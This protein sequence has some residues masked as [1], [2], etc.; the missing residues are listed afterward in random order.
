M[1]RVL[2]QG[3]RSPGDPRAS[4]SEQAIEEQE[5]AEQAQWISEQRLAVAP[6]P[7][8]LRPSSPPAMAFPTLQS[9]PHD[10]ARALTD[11]GA[12]VSRKEFSRCNDVGPRS[13]QGNEHLRA[14]QF[15]QT[16]PVL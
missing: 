6:E 14:S 7:I 9:N 13:G 8:Q 15:V 10:P 3:P 11:G 12:H 16:Q 4:P 1:Q 2:R 5:I